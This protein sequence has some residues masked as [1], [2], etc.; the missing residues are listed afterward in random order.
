MN[1][2]LRICLLCWGVVAAFF[3][4]FLIPFEALNPTLAAVLAVTAGGALLFWQVRYIVRLHHNEGFETAYFVVRHK[5]I[6]RF[7]SG[8]MGLGLVLWGSGWLLFPQQTN[9]QLEQIA[10]PLAKALVLLFWGTLIF[11][12]AGFALVCYAQTVGYARIKDFRQAAGSFALA[13]L[14]VVFAVLFCSLFL[15][16]INEVFRPLA[17][18]TQILVLRAVALTLTV[19][20]LGLGAMNKLNKLVPPE[21]L[22]NV[23]Q[24]PL[25]EKNGYAAGPKAT[26]RR[27]K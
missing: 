27:R 18:A 2:I 8:L 20:G 12:F 24:E 3:L 4:F 1:A 10:M 26:R 7:L 6:W 23:S 11:A 17:P 19:C 25:K 9:H 22:K 5:G 13:V 15:E 21:E 16:V 14:W